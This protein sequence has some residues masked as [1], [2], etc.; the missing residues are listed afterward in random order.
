MGTKMASCYIDCLTKTVGTESCLNSPPTRLFDQQ[1]VQVGKKNH[2]PFV[3]ES[4]HDNES[5]FPS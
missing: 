3:G 5:G 4:A 1:L 2:C